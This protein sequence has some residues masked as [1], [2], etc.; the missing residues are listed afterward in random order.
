MA[1]RKR[2]SPAEDFM[3][4]VALLPW[5]AGV[6]I[7]IVAYLVLH[8]FAT[9]PAPTLGKPGQLGLPLAQVMFRALATVGQYV[10]PLL[11]LAGAAA[12]A[13][14]RRQRAQ[15]LANVTANAATNSLEGI[16]WQEFEHLVGEAFRLQGYRVTEQGG[17]SADGG[18]DLVLS[19]DGEKVLV[20]CKQWRA[21]KVGVQVVRELYGVMA[22]VGASG[23]IVVTS[24]RFTDEA[25]DF[26]QGR[27][28]RLIDGP[29]LQTLLQQVRGT[30][31]VQE[32]A[33]N[34]IPACPL[35]AKPMTRRVARKGANAGGTFWGCTGFPTCRGV[36][37]IA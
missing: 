1:R 23:G 11:C 10:I 31:A 8:S 26:A 13:W 25:K 4:L 5:W 9:Q 28:V 37:P 30:R 34:L 17:A 36:K 20:Q 29:Q 35:C 27:N 32:P 12:S 16:S 15:L 3:D 6:A 19:K 18:V 22:A 14:R 2:T 7:A 33:R 21:F 24:G